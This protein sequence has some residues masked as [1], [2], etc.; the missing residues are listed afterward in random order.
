MILLLPPMTGVARSSDPS[1]SYTHSN[2]YQFQSRATNSGVNAMFLNNSSQGQSNNN[3]PTTFA[4]HWSTSY[5]LHYG[6]GSNQ[7]SKSNANSQAGASGMLPKEVSNASNPQRPSSATT[8]RLRSAIDQSQK[9]NTTTTATSAQA[10]NKDDSTN[11]EQNFSNVN[12]EDQEEMDGKKVDTSRVNPEVSLTTPSDSIELI[13]GSGGID[14]RNSTLS[15]AHVIESSGLSTIPNRFC[16]VSEAADLK[17]ILSL[18]KGS[19]GG[20]VPSS[21]AVMD[22]YMVGKVIGVGS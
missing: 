16:T 6:Y 7:G 20:I 13:E 18:S 9:Y 22:M 2:L 3:A 19:R 21:T 5:K 17:K 15:D 8:S 4:D 1:G 12:L 14:N 11:L 10:G